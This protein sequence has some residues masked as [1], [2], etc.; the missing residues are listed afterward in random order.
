[1]RELFGLTTR[2]LE[3]ENIP[4]TRRRGNNQSEFLRVR[5]GAKTD[6]GLVA[7]GQIRFLTAG[8]I[9]HSDVRFAF[10]G[11]NRKDAAAIGRPDRRSVA[12]AAR[13]SVVS[14]DA[15]ANVVIKITR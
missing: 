11:I 1:M 10:P 3:P 7:A 8:R 15:R 13:R 5:R 6:H 12:A 14:T 9:E 4:D 2:A